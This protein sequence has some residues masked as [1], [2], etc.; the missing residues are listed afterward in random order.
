M[1]HELL[2]IKSSTPCVDCGNIFPP[3]AME[4]DHIVPRVTSK[5]KPLNCNN[6]RSMAKLHS[7]LQKVE[8]R[9]ANCHAIRTHKEK[10]YLLRRKLSIHKSSILVNNDSLLEINNISKPQLSFWQI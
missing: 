5:D 10:H 1:R 9:C 8:L 7:E 6:I 4:F 3:E 2:K